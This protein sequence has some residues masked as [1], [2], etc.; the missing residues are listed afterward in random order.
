MACAHLWPPPLRG[1][2]ED[3]YPVMRS[4]GGFHMGARTGK[5]IVSWEM[6]T[7]AANGTPSNAVF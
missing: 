6:N 5:Q 4:L 3:L 1:L 7:V 2:C